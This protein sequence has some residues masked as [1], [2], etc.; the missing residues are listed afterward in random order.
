MIHKSSISSTGQDYPVS[1]S[2]Y[3]QLVHRGHNNHNNHDAIVQQLRNLNIHSQ[4]QSM[5]NGQE[6]GYRNP[7]VTD[8]LTP[9][10][11]SEQ[12][13]SYSWMGRTNGYSGMNGNGHVNGHVNGHIENVGRPGKDE[14]TS[15]YCC[16]VRC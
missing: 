3:G 16:L 6:N 4:P 13:F 5:Y 14:R 15:Q 1:S 9:P 2:S 10:H 8:C 11:N 12:S 7:I